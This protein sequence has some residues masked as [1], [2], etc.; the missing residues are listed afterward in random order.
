MSGRGLTCV[1]P[2]MTGKQ[3]GWQTLVKYLTHKWRLMIGSNI[4]ALA[5]GRPVLVVFFEDL[6]A[7]PAPQLVRMLQFLEMPSSPDIINATLTVFTFY[8]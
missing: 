5:A 4:R 2:C 3:T 1:L 8:F 7:D 6:K